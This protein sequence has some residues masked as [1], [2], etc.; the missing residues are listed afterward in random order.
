MRH[1]PVVAA[2][3]LDSADVVR[4]RT[5]QDAPPSPPCQ[6][7]ARDAQA[8]RRSPG[9]HTPGSRDGKIT[10]TPLNR[11]DAAR[12]VRASAA[13]SGAR[14]LVA[15]DV[16]AHLVPRV[17]RNRRHRPVAPDRARPV[18]RAARDAPVTKRPPATR[19]HGASEA[20]A[21]PRYRRQVRRGTLAGRT[22][23]RAR[24]SR[25]QPRDDVPAHAPP[26]GRSTRAGGTSTR[27]AVRHR[28]AL[29]AAQPCARSQ[30]P[31]ALAAST[32]AMPGGR[33]RPAALN[34]WTLA[35]LTAD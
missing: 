13:D 1:V 11:R 26:N 21:V 10:A 12:G 8:A 5:A 24:L 23:R 31:S 28:S 3:P 2:A 33:I 18:A 34:A 7:T 4:P 30:R 9:T 27:S 32:S 17:P 22:R 20:S 25:S 35:T 15:Y 6:P 14:P 29:D 19:A 16:R